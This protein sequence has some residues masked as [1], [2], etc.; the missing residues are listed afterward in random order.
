DPRAVIVSLDWGRLGFISC[1]CCARLLGFL[2]V[3][4]LELLVEPVDAPRGIDEFD[5]SSEV[6]VALRTHFDCD[7]RPGAASLK[8]IA[9]TAG[10]YAI[11]I[12]GVNSVF[13]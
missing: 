1:R 8:R 9:A 11:L 5:R 2:S 13:H 3:S 4:S 10:N 7:L 6:G 12:F